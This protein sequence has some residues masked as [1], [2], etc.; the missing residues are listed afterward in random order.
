MHIRAEEEVTHG[1]FI[2]QRLCLYLLKKALAL[3]TAILLAALLLEASAF[4]N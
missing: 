3:E 2:L 4:R 1:C